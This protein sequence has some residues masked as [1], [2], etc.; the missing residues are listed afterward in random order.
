MHSAQV[1]G[2]SARQIVARLGKGLLAAN[3]ATVVRAGLRGFR[4]L[5]S[6]LFE[7]YAAVDPFG[8]EERRNVACGVVSAR[9]RA[10]AQ[11]HFDSIPE[12]LLGLIVKELKSF[13]S[14]YRF[15]DGA[16]PWVDMIPLLSIVAD[17]KPKV[18]FE[19]GTYFGLTT[20]VLAM[21]HP[22]S[23]VHTIDLPEGFDPENDDCEIP[24]DDFHLIKNRRVGD[25]FRHDP[26]IKNVV[27]HFGDTAKWDYTPVKDAEL[28]FIDGSH[29]YEYIK[30]DTEKCLEACRGHKAT[31]LWHDV[32]PAYP[33]VV[34]YLSELCR[35]GAPVK[36]IC[37]T[38]MAYMDLE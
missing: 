13:G 16:L 20:R 33:G 17:R 4:G 6:R 12:I 15:V 10:V 14:D 29:T 8:L 23:I 11:M 5:D 34:R 32:H 38:H 22:E 19:I 35:S 36:R 18:M 31:F 26:S 30:N 28:F 1:R 25:G 3:M 7:A 37:W 21:A 9:E 24:K 2:L 27:Q